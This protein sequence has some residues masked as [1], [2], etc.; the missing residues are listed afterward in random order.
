MESKRYLERSDR[1]F[2]NFY[3]FR[4]C[5]CLSPTADYDEPIMKIYNFHHTKSKPSANTKANRY[6]LTRC[7]P[8]T[9]VDIF[10]ANGSSFLNV[11]FLHIDNKNQC[12]YFL[13][14]ADKAMSIIVDYA[15]IIAVRLHR[16]I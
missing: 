6:F 15:K 10:L 7:E 9:A 13:E 16:A 2:Y 4:K 8:G 11:Y 14:I 3:K 12:A 5:L 1:V